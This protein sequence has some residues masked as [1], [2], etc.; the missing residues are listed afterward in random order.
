MNSPLLKAHSKAVILFLGD[1]HTR[2]LDPDLHDDQHHHHWSDWLFWDKLRCDCIEMVGGFQYV[3]NSK[4]FRVPRQ[5]LRGG[6]GGV[7]SA[8]LNA[9]IIDQDGSLWT[10]SALLQH[11]PPQHHHLALPLNQHSHS[12]RLAPWTPRCPTSTS[13]SA[14]PSDSMSTCYSTSTLMP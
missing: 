6:G 9:V 2:E 4:Y 5:E 1:T 10:H 8:V 3:F 11:H 12:S 7:S 14:R 13:S